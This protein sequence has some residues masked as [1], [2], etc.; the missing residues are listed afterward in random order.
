MQTL[1]FL[2]FFCSSVSYSLLCSLTNLMIWGQNNFPLLKIF[3]KMIFTN[4][5][6]SL[7]IFIQ[8]LTLFPTVG[9]LKVFLFLFFLFPQRSVTMTWCLPAFWMWL[10]T[11]QAALPT[12]VSTT[13]L[14][15]ASTKNIAV[16]MAPATTCSILCGVPHS[17]LLK[18]FWNL[19]MIMDL[20]YQEVPLSVSLMDTSC[21]CRGW[22]LQ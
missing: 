14:T 19:S 11:C 2:L 5:S 15:F 9:Q 12:G 4:P 22:C 18:D 6:H 20:T 17:L 21:H 8:I 3:P 1:A 16:T 7:L 10:P 13:A